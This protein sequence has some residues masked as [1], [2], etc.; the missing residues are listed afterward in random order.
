MP[1]LLITTTNPG[2]LL[3]LRDLFRLP[4]LEL[5]DPVQVGL[6]LEV[7]ETGADY[8]ANARLKAA[9]FAGASG[10]W[11]LGDDTGLEVEALGGEPGVR[12]ARIVG[13]RASDAERQAALLRR[14]A[15]LP[16]P[17][18]ARF[19]CCL[20]LSSPQGAVETG[21]GEVRG[22]IVPEPRGEGGFGYDP[23]F[24]VEDTGQTMAE[25]DLE[26]KNRISH[27]ARAAQDLRPR[28]VRLM[29]L[30]GM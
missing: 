6:D 21:Q 19:R 29:G 25:L 24:L 18:A 22:E 15:N 23:L 13:P 10:L 5:V 3:E 30:K 12:S 28:L 27:R 17:W 1:R 20:A 9:A 2:K 4:G 16:R 11:A 8:A 26:T 7:E 14:L